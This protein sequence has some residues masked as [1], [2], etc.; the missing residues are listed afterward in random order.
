MPVVTSQVAYCTRAMHTVLFCG[1]SMYAVD[2][3]GKHFDGNANLSLEW[4][5]WPLPTILAIRHSGV[6]TKHNNDGI[7]QAEIIYLQISWG[8]RNQCVT[9]LSA[10]EGLGPSSSQ[11]PPW[12][13]RAH[14]L[15]VF[16]GL[17][18]AWP[19]GYGIM[20]SITTQRG[21]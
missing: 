20:S 8:P 11:F 5:W 14:R 12:N 6:R 7:T 13:F 18:W 4:H 19:L 2:A 15:A 16:R 17:Y 9:P 10:I 3:D 21:R 1:S